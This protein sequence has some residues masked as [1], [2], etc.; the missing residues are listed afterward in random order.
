MISEWRIEWSLPEIYST[1]YEEVINHFIKASNSLFLYFV[2]ACVHG[3][4]GNKILPKGKTLCTGLSRHTV[5]CRAA[6]EAPGAHKR[7]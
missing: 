1:L 2:T 6:Q 3:K 4:F 5:V 7:E